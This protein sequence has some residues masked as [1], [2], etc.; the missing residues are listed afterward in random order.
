MI[1][2][3]SGVNLFAREL[4]RMKHILGMAAIAAMLGA[5]APAR[6]DVKT[7]VDAWQQGDYAKAIAEWRPLAQTGDPDAQFNLGQAYKLGRGVPADLNVALDWYR[8]AAQQG[9]LR[10]EDN[11][12]LLM[13]QQGDRAAAIPYLQR[14]SARGEPRAQYIVGT[15]LF[16]GDLIGKDWVRAYALMTRASASGLPQAATSLEQMDKYIP[17]DQRKQGLALAAS[18]E[19]GD[20]GA[21]LAVAGPAP[22]RSAPST[23]RTTELPP[24]TPSQPVALP[25][26]PVVKPTPAAPRPAPQVAVAK[27]APARPASAVAAPSASGGWRVQLGAF[28]E[29]GRARALWSQLA[30]KVGGLSAYQPYLVKAGTVTRLQAGPIASGADAARL[31]GA[32][33][34]AG[35][36]C[37]PKK[38]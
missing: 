30:R 31:C 19:K 7:G 2:D 9:H 23:V 25:P 35:S 34:A 13:F 6:A 36:D 17:E 38:M 12:A 37:M 26:R 5:T 24:S 20:K 21:A 22:V 3:R 15:A 18:L 27:P 14:A 16:N 8:K 33:K 10:A 1:A 28:G 29:E 11:L 32:I 4:E